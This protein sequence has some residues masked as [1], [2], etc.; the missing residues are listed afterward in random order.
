M[1]WKILSYLLPCENSKLLIFCSY[2]CC[3]HE[4]K[5]HFID[6]RKVVHDDNV[7]VDRDKH[8]LSG[9]ESPMIESTTGLDYIKTSN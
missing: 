6:F 5:A 2:L 1:K 4:F 7:T 8:C 9:R 3:P